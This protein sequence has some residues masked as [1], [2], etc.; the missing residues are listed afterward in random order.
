[1]AVPLN[2]SINVNDLHDLDL[3]FY[4]RPSAKAEVLLRLTIDCKIAVAHSKHNKNQVLFC[5][6]C[7][8]FFYCLPHKSLAEDFNWKSSYVYEDELFFCWLAIR[9]WICS[10]FLF[11]CAQ[12]K[13]SKKR[14][15][16]EAL[17]ESTAGGPLR[18]PVETIKP[19]AK[20][21]IDAGVKVR[22]HKNA[23]SFPCYNIYSWILRI[24]IIKFF[25]H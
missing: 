15:G 18:L 11:A 16:Q 7:A 5:L 3:Q 23:L 4:H 9:L 13:T 21:F 25:S 2:F 19:A 22:M 6:V 14:V 10:N 17:A 8:I 12:N 1:L 24:M 20:I